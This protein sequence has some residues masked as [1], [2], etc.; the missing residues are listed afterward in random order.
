MNR[1]LNNLFITI[2][3]IDGAGKSTFIPTILELIRESGFNPVLTREPGGTPLGEE[4]REL[5]LNKEMD[6]KTEVLLA[7]S[8]RNEHIQ[9]VIIPELEKGNFVISDRFTD[10]TKVY[11]GYAQNISEDYI[12]TLET[13]V[14]GSLNPNLTLIFTVPLD[15]SRARLKKTNKTPDKFESKNDD[16]FLKIIKGY[17][18]LAATNPNRYVLIDSSQTKEYTEKQVRKHLSR[19]LNSISSAYQKKENKSNKK[20]EIKPE[21]YRF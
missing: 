14:Q 13:L 3:G 11:Q 12:K 9:K 4:I 18:T 20:E 1:K 2:E 21:K 7:F 5:L 10:S 19:Y 6:K 8:A 15:V 17:E 16:Y